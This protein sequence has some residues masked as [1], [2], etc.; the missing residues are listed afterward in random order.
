MSKIFPKCVQ[1]MS[2]ILLKYNVVLGLTTPVI[3]LLLI[4][5]FL[6][7]ILYLSFSNQLENINLSQV[8][9]YFV[10]CHYMINL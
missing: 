1:P 10:I 5:S 2:K 7:I 9:V 8:A 4:L 6:I 3:E